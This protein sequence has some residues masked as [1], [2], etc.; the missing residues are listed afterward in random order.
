MYPNQF[1]WNYHHPSTQ[2]AYHNGDSVQSQYGDN[3]EGAW[4][5]QA[6]GL[7]RYPIP[8]PQPGQGTGQF[9]GAPG[10][11]PGQIP[12]AQ[13]PGTGATLAPPPSYTPAQTQQATFAVDPGSIA[14]C[15]FRYTYVWLRNFEQFWFYPVFVGRNS[16]AGFRWNGFRWNYFG[17]SL[18]QINSFTCF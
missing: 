17:M 3:A 1:P 5:G 7:P 18:R 6:S 15:L 10:Q 4:Y 2:E 12:G 16:V 11:F 9:P 13:G 14:G 8:F